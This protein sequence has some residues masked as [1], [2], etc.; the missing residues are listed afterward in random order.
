MYREDLFEKYKIKAPNTM[1]E[2][3][4]S[5]MAIQEAV[6]NDGKKD[7]YGITARGA[8]GAGYIGWIVASTWAPSWNVQF[9]NN[10]E[11]NIVTEEH[12]SA[13]EHFVELLK[14]AGPPE[15]AEMEWID[16]LRYYEEGK[17]AMIIEVGMEFA[18]LYKKGGT[19]MENSR[20]KLIPAGPT[21][22]PHP[23]LYSPSFAI[24]KKS[25][26][27]E[28]S[29]ELMKFL[30]SPEQQLEDAL[31]S[32]AIE[33]SR[34]TVLNNPEMDRYF[35]KDLLGVT[36]INRKYAKD[37]RP[38]SRH[39]L[40]VSAILGDEYNLVLKGEKT[41][42]QALEDAAKKIESLGKRW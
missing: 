9:Y 26:V 17:S 23:G 5:S 33:T 22:V 28:A 18:H 40:K 42:K 21:G 25:K 31:L 19:I 4:E 14:K 37:E 13:L 39:G 11:L 3:L 20:C 8:K 35:N 15:Q 7:F 2:L 27:K 1:K 38:Y 12:I 34:K 24:P 29:W 36:R 32:D 30:C 41:A 16:S 6:R 10:N